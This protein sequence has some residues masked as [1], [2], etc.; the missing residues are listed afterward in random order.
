MASLNVSMLSEYGAARHNLTTEAVDDLQTTFKCC[1]AE[2]FEDWRLASWWSSEGRHSNKVRPRVL[3]I[4]NVELET[5]FCE[6]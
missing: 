1:G 6:V 5:N 2:S 4:C 3:L